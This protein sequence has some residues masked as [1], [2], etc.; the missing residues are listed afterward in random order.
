MR[1]RPVVALVVL[2]LLS[3]CGGDDDGA[4]PPASTRAAD[5]VAVPVT[6]FRFRATMPAGWSNVS[7]QFADQL[8]TLDAAYAD[9]A[10]SGYKP[11]LLV[12]R[13]RSQE[14]KRRTVAE[15]E[16][17]DR[18][19]A[20]R[21]GQEVGPAT[22]LRVDGVPAIRTSASQT[23]DGQRLVRQQ[24]LILRD[25][26]LY[27]VGLTSTADDPDAEGQLDGVLAS[28]RWSS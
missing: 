5:E 13:E 9:R 2:A 1:P 4:P 23:Q 26:T 7:D 12:T 16:A 22:T 24:V 18:R 19:G 14:L 11:N 3:G 17:R 6:G 25:G 21:A 28:W 20:E 10:A 27:V 8:T 15:V